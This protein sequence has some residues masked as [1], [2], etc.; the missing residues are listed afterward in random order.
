M[1]SGVCVTWLSLE[2]QA[3]CCHHDYKLGLWNQAT[4]FIAGFVISSLRCHVSLK[5]G[6]FSL[7][8]LQGGWQLYLPVLYRVLRM[9]K[10][11]HSKRYQ[12]PCLRGMQAHVLAC[13]CGTGPC[14]WGFQMKLFYKMQKAVVTYCKSGV[15]IQWHILCDLGVSS[16]VFFISLQVHAFAFHI[17]FALNRFLWNIEAKFNLKYFP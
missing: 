6:C 14:L 13:F 5:S 15:R 11:L 12:K 1:L 9:T 16:K 4:G 10:G 3:I 2:S 8:A 17:L 7:L